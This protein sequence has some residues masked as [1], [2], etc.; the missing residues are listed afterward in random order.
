ME[1]APRLR[2]KVTN[3]PVVRVMT[4]VNLGNHF[5]LFISARPP[6][7]F[8][9][10]VTAVSG[11]LDRRHT[12]FSP[13]FPSRVAAMISATYSDIRS[14]RLDQL[15]RLLRRHGQIS[16]G[17]QADVTGGPEVQGGLGL[18]DQCSHT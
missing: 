14:H 9:P 7:P 6:F 3:L 16:T 5:E 13:F 1:Q 4:I 17:R 15:H 12:H 10:P 8:P 18:L 2:G 11:A